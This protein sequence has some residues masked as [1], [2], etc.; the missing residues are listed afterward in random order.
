MLKDWRTELELV[1]PETVIRWRKRRLREFR[2][3]VYL[4]C[5]ETERFLIEAGK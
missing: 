2:F 5:S 3:P 4:F 1:K